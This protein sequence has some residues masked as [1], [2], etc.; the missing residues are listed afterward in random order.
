MWGKLYYFYRPDRLSYGWDNEEHFQFEGNIYCKAY[1]DDQI[2]KRVDR[3]EGVTTYYTPLIASNSCYF[4]EG[5]Q[6]F[7]SIKDSTI[8]YSV[9]FQVDRDSYSLP[10]SGVYVILGDGS[11]I[12]DE[13]ATVKVNNDKFGYYYQYS[14]LLPLSYADYE[15]ICVHGIEAFKVGY[16][17]ARDVKVNRK[18]YIKRYLNSLL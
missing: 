11:Q 3:Y 2:S 14:A 5:V 15:R 12:R 10:K 18:E 16:M 6:G 1:Y 13:S 17:E 9:L 8:I 7:K 4:A